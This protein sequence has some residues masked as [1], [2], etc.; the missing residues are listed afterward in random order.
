MSLLTS[1]FVYKRQLVKCMMRSDKLNRNNQGGYAEITSPS[2]NVIVADENE[3]NEII[4]HENLSENSSTD[5]SESERNTFIKT[6]LQKN[7]VDV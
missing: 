7:S 4:V 3:S 6:L 5:V 1:T 2:S